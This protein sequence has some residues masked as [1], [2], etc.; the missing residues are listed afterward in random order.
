MIIHELDVLYEEEVD[1]IRVITGVVS[2]LSA[3][4][5]GSL[6]DNLKDKHKT[7]TVVAVASI[8]HEG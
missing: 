1:G 5:L 8:T 3:K 6:T 4:A 2:N 7:K